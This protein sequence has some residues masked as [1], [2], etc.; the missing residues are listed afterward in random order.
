M[1]GTLYGMITVASSNQYTH[2]A[3]TSFFKHTKL[4]AEDRFVLIDNDGEWTKNWHLDCFDPNL[5]YVNSNPQNFSTNIN[6]LLRWAD[7]QYADLVFL[8][9]DVVFT[10]K[11]A[12]RLVINDRTVSIPSCNQTHFYGFDPTLNLQ[13]FGGRFPHLNVA[14]HTHAARSPAP[15]ERLLMPTYVCR[16]PRLIYQEV[17]G[18]D[19]AFNMG[20]ED[21]D[22]RLRL[23]QK[24]FEIKYCSSYLLHFNG[25]SSWNGAETLAETQLRNRLYMQTFIEKWGEDLHD[26]CM[27]SGQPTSIIEKYQLHGLLNECR[28]NDIIK[29]L[30]TA[31]E[32][33]KVI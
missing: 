8:S 7:E 32:F 2:V 26:L 31:L 18:F 19:E 21:V 13:Q 12:T 16:I 30:L 33:N 1:A 25:C 11:W 14:A 29:S 4:S 15:F 24:G 9:N 17:G 3:L 5:V 28:F 22:Y 6:Q 27:S 10:P 23:L 20:G